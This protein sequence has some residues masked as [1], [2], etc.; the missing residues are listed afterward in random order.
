[1]AAQCKTCGKSLDVKGRKTLTGLAYSTLHD[2][3]LE[4]ASSNMTS[5][6][7]HSFFSHG[8]PYLCKSCHSTLTKYANL[9]QHLDAIT[10]S[11]LSALEAEKVVPREQVSAE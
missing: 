9:W 3:V 7:V 1:M 5:S 6:T 8:N 11:T 2:L 10:S 4:K